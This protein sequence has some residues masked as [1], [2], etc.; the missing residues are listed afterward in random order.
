M[1]RK[2]MTV[3]I[4][5]ILV[6][7]MIWT[8]IFALLT[9]TILFDDYMVWL[10]FE[11][12]SGEAATVVSINLIAELALDMERLFIILFGIVAIVYGVSERISGRGKGG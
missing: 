8:G 10:S 11:L 1:K 9:I 12:V 7:L 4:L 3:T 2:T 5:M 6:A